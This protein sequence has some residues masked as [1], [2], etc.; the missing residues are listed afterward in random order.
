MYLLSQ[1]LYWSTC[2]LHRSP[3]LVTLAP[4]YKACQLGRLMT[5]VD[6]KTWARIHV[7]SYAQKPDDGIGEFIGVSQPTV[8]RTVRRVT[9][10]FVA[11]ADIHLPSQRKADTNK[12][13]FYRAGGM[14]NIIG[15]VDGTHVRIQAPHG[16]HA[17]EF[18]NRKNFFSINVQI[19]CGPNLEIMNCV[20]KWASSVH[21]AR[22][23]RESQLFAAFEGNNKPLQGIFLADSGYMLRDWLLT[24]LTNP[25]TDRERR[26]NA[27]HC[28]T[29][30][31]VERSIGVLKRR[32]HCLHVELRMEPEAACEI[33]FACVF[34][35]NCAIKFG[36]GVPEDEDEPLDEAPDNGAEPVNHLQV[37][38]RMRSMIGRAA[39]QD[40]INNFFA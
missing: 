18:L 19:V 9:K 36:V 24:P 12:E 30:S 23:L 4:Q 21:D 20:A 2:A 33:I 14:P 35:H 28:S 26:Y 8:S 31:A 5:N 1:G 22:I 10:A 38:E 29:R 13:Q 39:R 11:I 17:Q 27:A 25:A 34:L 16:D 37:T 40:L 32:W 15:C 3:V 6:V 7:K